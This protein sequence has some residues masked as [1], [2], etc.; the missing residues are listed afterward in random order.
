M[1]NCFCD[2]KIQGEKSPT[3]VLRKTLQL[4]MYED[5]SELHV[6]H[7]YPGRFH[8]HCQKQ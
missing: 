8:T 3:T 7:G 2:Q 5:Q 1:I 4:S 6:C